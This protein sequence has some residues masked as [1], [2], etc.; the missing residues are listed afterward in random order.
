M[1]A[2]P[3]RALPCTVRP[4][5]L[6]TAFAAESHQAIAARD[7]SAPWPMRVAAARLHVPIRPR[8]TP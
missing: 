8:P 2:T 7:V 4:A 5:Y 3:R 1:P 6:A